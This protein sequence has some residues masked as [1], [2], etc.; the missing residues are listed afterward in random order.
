M[1]NPNI[2]PNGRIHQIMANL[3]IKANPRLGKPG[4]GKEK[5][6]GRPSKIK[7]PSECHKAGQ[8]RILRNPSTNVHVPYRIY[9]NSAVMQVTQHQ[10]AGY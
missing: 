10:I 6:M 2:C 5:E 1:L 8:L 3:K 7:I 9:S 4:T